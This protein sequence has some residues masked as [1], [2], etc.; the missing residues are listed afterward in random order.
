MPVMGKH[1]GEAGRNM[2]E[3]IVIHVACFDKRDRRIGV[4]GEIT[5][6]DAARRARAN[7]DD[8]IVSWTSVSF[9]FAPFLSFNQRP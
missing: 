1:F 2:D 4:F 9:F 8:V 7:N 6:N 3:R 5:R